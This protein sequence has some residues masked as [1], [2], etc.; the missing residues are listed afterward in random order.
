MTV[1]KKQSFGKGAEALSFVQVSSAEGC[2][3]NLVCY[4]SIQFSS[5]N[6]YYL[7]GEIQYDI[8]VPKSES[9]YLAFDSGIP[10]GP[11][12]KSKIVTRKINKNPPPP[13]KKNKNKKTKQNK[14][15]T[16]TNQTKQNKQQQ[17]QQQNPRVLPQNISFRS[18][19]MSKGILLSRARW[20]LCSE[21]FTESCGYLTKN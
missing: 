11:C 8:L 6:L 21:M 14:T 13:Q 17:Q 2:S 20:L 5:I 1:A 7:H 12:L 3:Q 18:L 19:V 4:Y 15:K 10:S 9:N 16:K